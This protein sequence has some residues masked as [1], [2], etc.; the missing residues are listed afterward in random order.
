M[1]TN[2]VIAERRNVKRGNGLYDLRLVR[3]GGT[4]LTIEVVQSYFFDFVPNEVNHNIT[5]SDQERAEFLGQ[6]RAQI[7]STWNKAN[8]VTINGHA[9]SIVFISNIMNAPAGTQWQVRVYKLKNASSSRQSSV[10]RD[11]FAGN[12]DA[13]LDS[14]DWRVRKLHGQNTQTGLIHEFGHTIGNGDEYKSSSAHVNDRPSVMNSGATVRDR[15]LAHFVS[16]AR[17]YIEN[18][19]VETPMSDEDHALPGFLNRSRA[20]TA[21]SEVD[22]VREW[23]EGIQP[24]NGVVW[25][26]LRRG[27]HEPVPVDEADPADFENLEIVFEGIAGATG[28]LTWFPQS[29]EAVEALFEGS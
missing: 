4:S 20:A 27:S 5:W 22:S 13:A 18:L 14:N 6:W 7:P 28:P 26:V 29:A 1:A 19:T 10:W 23:K 3:A 15:H 25:E 21:D 24:D 8:H 12:Y 11:G 9:V 2:P 16:W 17:P